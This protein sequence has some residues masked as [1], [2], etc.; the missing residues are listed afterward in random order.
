MPPSRPSLEL[1]GLSPTRRLH[2]KIGRTGPAATDQSSGAEANVRHNPAA[3]ARKHETMR[4][5]PEIRRFHLF[6]FVAIIWLAH[7]GA[8][9]MQPDSFAVGNPK[10]LAGDRVACQRVALGEPGDYKPCVA[11]L[12]GGELLL[13]AFHQHARDGG[14]VMEQ[15]LLFRSADGGQTWS[16]PEKLDL[17]GREPYLTVLTDGTLF[18]TGHLLPQDV[19]NKYGYTHGYLHRSTDKG[20]SWQSTR[21][22]SEGI[23]PG[24]GNHSSRNVLELADGKLLVGV[25][26]DG[27]G[28]PYFVWRSSDR[29]QSWEK[30]TCDPVGFKSVYGFF[31]GETWLW[32]S[33]GGR[34][35]AL[36]RVDSN[37][38]PLASRPI[39]AESDQSDHFLLYASDDLGRTFRYVKPLGNY[40]E[41][42]M[43]ILRLADARLLLTF[44]VRDLSPP[45]GVRAIPGLETQG[46]FEFD[47]SRDRLMLD[48]KTGSRQQGGGFG[49]T[50]QLP[51]GTL[52]TSYSYRGD[53]DETHLEVVRWTL[54]AKR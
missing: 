6:A 21:I 5:E 37:E 23:K 12:P 43:S 13:T 33:R 11:R 51:D 53:D 24:A 31:G 35:W 27:G 3:H 48:I 32:Q 50:V 45:L 4:F 40:G 17:L 19:R 14:K 26:Y 7:R 30:S 36:V 16:A 54:P 38:F 10:T 49:P 15:T 42:Y 25:D 44:T 41:M 1:P 20:R 18:L 52:V 9:A 22:E 46:G 34:V 29:G 39:K 28:G 2:N 8:V 47:F